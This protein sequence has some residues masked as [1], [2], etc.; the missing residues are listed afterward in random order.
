[1]TRST[2][3]RPGRPRR[4]SDKLV[5]RALSWRTKDQIC[6]ELGISKKTFDY[7]RRHEHKSPCP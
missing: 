5:Q 1:M 3:R 7:L 2:P 4:Y 6:A